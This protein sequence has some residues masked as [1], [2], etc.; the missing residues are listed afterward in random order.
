MGIDVGQIGRLQAGIAQ[1][2]RN[3]CRLAARMG[4]ADMVGIAGDA[5]T[6]QRG[7]DARTA[8]QGVPGRFQHEEH[9]T[10]GEHQSAAIA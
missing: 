6:R 10:L 3:G 2:R 1:R 8:R 4:G 5:V 7:E 9:R